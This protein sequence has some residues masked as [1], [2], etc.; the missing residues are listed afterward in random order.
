M[1]IANTSSR[2]RAIPKDLPP[3]STL[4]YYSDLG[5]GTALDRIHNS[6]MRS[7]TKPPRA[8]PSPTAAI[9]DSQSVTSGK[10]PMRVDGGPT[11]WAELPH[12]HEG[13]RC[14]Q[15]LPRPL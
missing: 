13:N 1:Y 7:V 11:R 5:V 15:S 2:W 9:I 4:Y 8:R 10:D 12:Q 3:R 6:L 14:G